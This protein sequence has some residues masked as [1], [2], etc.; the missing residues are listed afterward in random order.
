MLALLVSLF[1]HNSIYVSPDGS[2]Y[3]A[4]TAEMPLRTTA[5]ALERIHVWREGRSNEQFAEVILLAGTHGPINVA[6]TSNLRV[7]AASPGN[8]T[9]SGGV[10]VPPSSFSPHPTLPNVIIADVSR[11]PGMP[12]PGTWGKIEANQ[13]VHECLNDKVELIFNSERQ[14]HARESRCATRVPGVT[15]SNPPV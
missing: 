13:G 9:I 8:T 7:R 4:G 15:A 11:L 10:S 1:S 5:A 6:N 14:V 3:A 2:D 12:V